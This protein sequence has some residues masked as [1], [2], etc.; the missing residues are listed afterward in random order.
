MLGKWGS[1]RRYLGELPE[2]FQGVGTQHGLVSSGSEPS[3]DRGLV[4][5][6]EMASKKGQCKARGTNIF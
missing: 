3:P 6:A 4:T 1:Y 2:P 5:A